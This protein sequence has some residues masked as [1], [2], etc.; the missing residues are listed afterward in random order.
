MSALILARLRSNLL[1]EAPNPL[2]HLWPEVADEALLTHT[3]TVRRGAT[4]Q[5]NSP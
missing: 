3:S 2:L 5:G 1:T 4:M